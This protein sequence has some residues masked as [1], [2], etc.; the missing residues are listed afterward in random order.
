M[1]E[2]KPEIEACEKAL[3]KPV[4]LVGL[5]GSGKTRVGTNLAHLLKLEFFDTD[6]LIEAKAGY[7][8][9]EIF[10]NDGEPKFREVERKTILDLLDKGPCIIAAGGGTIM[11]EGVPEALKQKAITIWLKTDI[12]ELAHRL[13]NAHNRPL[14]KSGDPKEIL[15]ALAKKREPFYA[16]ADVTVK[17]AGMQPAD[18]AL[19]LIK[20][21]CGF[22][23]PGNL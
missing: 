17:T 10:E 8:I 4:V 2:K 9:N 13:R 11:N 6:R 1:S 3:K 15:A 16:Q 21:L 19:Q 7:T 22:L 5:M 23:K 14:L 18:T 12:N 20:A